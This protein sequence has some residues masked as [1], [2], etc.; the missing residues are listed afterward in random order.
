[1]NNCSENSGS[2]GA[3]ASSPAVVIKNRAINT[4]TTE[5]ANVLLFREAIG[6]GLILRAR[7]PR[8]Q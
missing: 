3:R 4:N 5:A 7:R 2:L 8:S 1:V 6:T